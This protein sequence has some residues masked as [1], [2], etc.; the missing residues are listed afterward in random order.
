MK[1][2]NQ[3]KIFSENKPSLRSI[4]TQ[5]DKLAIDPVTKIGLRIGFVAIGIGLI[6]LALN[7]GKLPPEVP[8]LYSRPYGENQLISVW[9]LWLLPALSLVVELVSIKSAGKVIDDDRLL[10]QILILTGGLAT[11]MALVTLIK[12]VLLVV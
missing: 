5:M 4:K 10:A 2:L 7:W 8:L 12:I 11:T 6:I 9:G 3:I 1:K